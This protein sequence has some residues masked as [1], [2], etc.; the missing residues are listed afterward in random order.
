ME[1]R[2]VTLWF[3][4]L[5]GAGKTTISE[6][7]SEKLR[8]Q[9]YKFEVL[10]GDIVRQNL[11]KGLGFSKE[12]RDENIRRIGFVAHLLTRNDVIVIVSAISPYREIRDEVRGRIGDFVEVFVNAP[13]EVCESRDV[14][15]LYKRARAGEIKGF[16]GID[17]PYEPPLNPE[18]ECRTDKE[19][20]EESV[21]KVFD[22][23]KE[24]GYLS[25]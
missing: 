15:G 2:G 12:D 20:L 23:L 5:S 16:T 11:T 19:E 13:L 18:I 1:Q 6:A 4:G 21:A 25:S 9:G 22:K 3:T 8:S 10:D 24:L 17:D 14:K 7:V